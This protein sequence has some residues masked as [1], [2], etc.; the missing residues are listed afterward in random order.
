MASGLYEKARQK[1]LEGGIAILTDNIKAV[2]V[3]VADYTV[4]LGT[5]EFLSDIV[6]AGRVAISAN[7]TSKSS[8]L[9]IFNANPTV[10]SAV[11]G[12]QS[13]AVVLFKDTGTAST[14]PLILYVDSASSG[15]PVTPNGGDITLNFDTGTNKIFKL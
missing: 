7:L 6:L 13:E 1:F 14:S 5:H 2:L 11:T 10:F 4:N 12:D 9:G 3:D 8:A 15:L